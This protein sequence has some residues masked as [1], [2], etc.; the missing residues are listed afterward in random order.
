MKF[1][2]LM[3]L[4]LVLVL[5]LSAFAACNDPAETTPDAGETTPDA[6][7]TTPDAGETTPDAG[8]TTP[9]VGETTPECE[10]RG[11]KTGNNKDATCAEEGY[12]EYK[13][14][15]CDEIYTKPLEK[16]AHTYGEFQSLDGAYTK[17]VCSVCKESKV[18]DATGA[19]VADASAIAFPLFAATFD[20]VQTLE[21]AASLFDGFSLTP[22]F[23]NIVDT[24]PSGEI[25]L[26]IPTGTAAT[27]PNGCLD[28]VDQNAQ[29]VG[30]AFT[31][32][33]VARFDEFP[34]EATAL[35]SWTVDGNKQVILS[36]NSKGEYVDAAGNVVAKSP[37]K[38]WD[39]IKVTFAADGSYTVYLASVG[40]EMAE[41]QIATGKVATTGSSSSIR[42]FDNVS[43]FEAYLD[44]IVIAK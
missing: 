3:A 5:I 34:A 37:K 32:S 33:F 40:A 10:H 18:Y 4:A 22:T 14:T 20:G 25:Y 38:G 19:E 36:A 29:L 1:T 12:I 21:Q 8:E 28:L 7:E 13:C 39:T 31:L 24:D 30:Q 43:K 42:F 41:T 35:L 15:K 9:D 16:L 26:N 17:K 27:A 44:T 2:K 23:A 11:K 6:G